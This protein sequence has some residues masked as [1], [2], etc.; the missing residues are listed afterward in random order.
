MLKADNY[1]IITNGYPCRVPFH[2][3]LHYQEG[4]GF[5]PSTLRHLAQIFGTRE[6]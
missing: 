3:R 2:Y 6:K 1:M 4:K 5:P